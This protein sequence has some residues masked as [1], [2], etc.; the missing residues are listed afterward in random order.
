[1]K[2]KKALVTGGAGFIGSHLAEAL[3]D[4]GMEVVVLD[5]LSVGKKENVPEQAQLVVGDVRD[6]DCVE[7]VLVNDEVDIVFHEAALVTI[8]GSMDRFMEDA[9]TNLLGTVN[10]LDALRKS[11]VK[12]LVF[13]SSMAVYADSLEPKPIDEAYAVQPVSPY[14]IAKF[15]SEQYCRLI[16]RMLS[17]DCIVLRYFN[18]YGPRQTFTPY[19]G[20]ITIFINQ[21]L[22]GKDL[23]IFGDGEQRRD[24]IHVD[25][26]VQANLL[27]M[28]NEIKAGLFNVGS[29]RGTSINEIAAKLIGKL[30][31]DRQPEYA[32]ARPEELRNSIADIR[33]L[34]E[35]LG[36][37]PRHPV[38]DPGCV[39]EYWKSQIG[40]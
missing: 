11:K 13:A 17:I 14:G 4:S 38:L 16:C 35:S 40:E 26:I 24:F 32:P 12:K 28:E 25:D 3:V 10:I 20:V 19:V 21:L 8:R 36:F 9:D 34:K 30:A 18:T 7:N 29:G 22:K 31:P 39:V 2:Y 33:S 6:R 23:T 37:A 1:M 15:A 5:N 27:S